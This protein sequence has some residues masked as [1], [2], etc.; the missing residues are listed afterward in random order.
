MAKFPLLTQLTIEFCRNLETIDDLLYLP[1]IEE[2]YIWNCGLVGKLSSSEGFA[3]SM[4]S[5]SQLPKWN[6]LA[7][8]PPKALLKQ[9]WGFLCKVSQLPGEPQ[10]PQDCEWIVSVPGHLWSTSLKSLETFCFT[11]VKSLYQL[12]DQTQ[13][14]I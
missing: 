2:I 4:V 3:H 7:A 1:A 14:R 6:G 8:V 13:L 11:I 12:V 10:R 9:L 5:K